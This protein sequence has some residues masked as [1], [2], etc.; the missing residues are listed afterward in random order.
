MSNMSVFTG[1]VGFTKKTLQLVWEKD[2]CGR[3][4]LRKLCF[5]Y[6]A[7]F[8][9]KKKVFKLGRKRQSFSSYE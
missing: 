7:L 5:T 8:N 4:S 6:D 2:A 9:K 3:F 1:T